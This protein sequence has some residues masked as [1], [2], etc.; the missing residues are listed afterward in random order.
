MKTKH[1]PDGGAAQI[2]ARPPALPA[3]H[4]LRL[5]LGVG[6]QPARQLGGKAAVRQQNRVPVLRVLPAFLRG[7]PAVGLRSGLARPDGGNPEA[8]AEP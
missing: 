2:T 5:Q 1:A 4:L 3:P 8:G 6:L 7:P